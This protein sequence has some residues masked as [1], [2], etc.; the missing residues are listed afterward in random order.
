VRILKKKN[1]IKNIVEKTIKPAIK[2][3]EEMKNEGGGKV[4]VA[5]GH[6]LDTTC[7]SA[8]FW[9]LSKGMGSE[10]KNFPSKNNFSLSEDF[11]DLLEK[12]NPKYIIIPDVPEIKRSLFEKM[13][14]YK[15]LIVDHHI[16]VD[17]YN[18]VFYSNPKI[19]DPEIYIPAS[20]LAYK[21]SKKFLDDVSIDPIIWIASIGV[22][23]DKGVKNCVDLFDDLKVRH[24]E[25]LNDRLDERYLFEKT[26]L[27][28]LTKLVGSSEIILSRR[29]ADYS[30]KLL[31]KASS[32]KE[33]MKNEK[34]I[35]LDNIVREEFERLERDF[36]K[37]KRIQN[38]FIFFEVRSKYNIRSNFATYMSSL[39]KDKVLVVYQKINGYYDISF[40]GSK[41]GVHLGYLARKLAKYFEDASGG[42]HRQAAGARVKGE[43]LDDY[44]KKLIEI[45]YSV[46]NKEK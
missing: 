39:I 38:D 10:V 26:L 12:E 5:H 30:V 44:L 33:V 18:E 36:E 4:I 8:I 20:Y 31:S 11:L 2:F 24:P 6:D 37:N 32:Y 42:G 14:K 23:S 41:E 45:V 34:L 43:Y 40:R 27:G 28:K 29:G 19:F 16:P 13:R 1:S 3:F 7:S 25:L 21:I 9:K 35:Q 17:Y 22:L 15:V 46:E